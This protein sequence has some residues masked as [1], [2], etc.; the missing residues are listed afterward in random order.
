MY[1]YFHL[2][3]FHAQREKFTASQ[4]CTEVKHLQLLVTIR[5]HLTDCQTVTQVDRAP[6]VVFSDQL[7]KPQVPLSVTAPPICNIAGY[8]VLHTRS[9]SIGWSTDPVL[10]LYNKIHDKTKLV[11]N[12]K[13]YSP[14]FYCMLPSL[15][16]L[17]NELLIITLHTYAI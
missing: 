1:K 14:N 5:F 2:G 6:L 12:L 4:N 10:T 16:R 8:T 13:V 9:Q 17:I 11:N 7:K 3:C 15:D